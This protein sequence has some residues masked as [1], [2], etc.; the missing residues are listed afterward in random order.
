MRHNVVITSLPQAFQV[1]K[2]MNL[3][4]KFRYKD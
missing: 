3:D 1:I 2:E 4:L